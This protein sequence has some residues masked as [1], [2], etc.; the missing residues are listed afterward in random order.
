[1][2]TQTTAAFIAVT[3]FS[4]LA[5]G[6]TPKSPVIP[7]ELKAP[8][9]KATSTS[10]S[11]V[12]LTVFSELSHIERAIKPYIGNSTTTTPVSNTDAKDCRTVGS[13]STAQWE[14]RWA[15]GLDSAVDGKKEIEGVERVNFD[16]ATNILTYT[17]AL[18]TRNYNGHEARQ[19]APTLSTG[20]RIKV[21]F[22]RNSTETDGRATFTIASTAS[23]NPTAMEGSNWKIGIEGTLVRKDSTWTI[24]PRAQARFDGGL[25]GLD[26]RRRNVLAVGFYSFV[27]DSVTS[28]TGL[29]DSA[30]TK[31]AGTWKLQAIGAG[32][33]FD[34]VVET[35][36]TGGVRAETSLLSWPSSLCALP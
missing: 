10:S 18:E 12:A 31:P 34:T 36:E 20:R 13:S 27:S 16:K 23:V 33:N 7:E 5:C 24:E 22:D 3:V 2:R 11:E 9:M 19:T 14:T 26:D 1:M 17:A 6:P 28:L 35:T 15:C 8:A 30:C 29:G 32:E 25:Y 4:F 21:I